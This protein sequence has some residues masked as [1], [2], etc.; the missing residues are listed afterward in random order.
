MTIKRVN[1]DLFKTVNENQA[2]K[3]NIKGQ[4]IKA[5]L[6]IFFYTAEALMPK[7]ILQIKKLALTPTFKN[8]I[9][10]FNLQHKL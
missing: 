10:T 7:K 4:F 3:M 6:Y 2:G 5:I 8:S 1:H 9:D